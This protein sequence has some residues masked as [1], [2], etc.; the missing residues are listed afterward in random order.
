MPSASESIIFP[1][2]LHK[3]PLDVRSPH[4]PDAL[5][6]PDHQAGHTPMHQHGRFTRSAATLSPHTFDDPLRNS[7]TSSP[8]SPNSGFVF[9]NATGLNARVAFTLSYSLSTGVRRFTRKH[10]R[11]PNTKLFREFSTI[12][13]ASTFAARLRSR[14]LSSVVPGSAA[15]RSTRYFESSHANKL[16]SALYP[17]LHASC[18]EMPSVVRS[19]SGEGFPWGAGSRG[20]A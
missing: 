6:P 3:S 7:K 1:A 20:G 12:P 8:S 13:A 19:T 4:A 9:M 2:K 16:E 11:Q 17:T 15:W 14:L 5:S 18:P 10:L